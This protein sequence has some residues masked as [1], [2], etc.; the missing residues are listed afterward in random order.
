MPD[1]FLYAG[2]ANPTDIKLTDPTVVRSSGGAITGTASFV[3]SGEVIQAT[4]SLTIVGTASL[5]ESG[6]K[7]SA[8]A[9]ETFVSTSAFKEASDNLSA[10]GNELFTST[11][12][13]KESS[14]NVSAVGEQTVSSEATFTESGEEINAIG[15]ETFVSTIGL[16]ESGEKINATASEDYL[17]TA[18]LKEASDNLSATVTV[19][20]VTPVDIT[21]TASMVE[22]SEFIG[23]N[24]ELQSLNVI[25]GSFQGRLPSIYADKVV[26]YIPTSEE[27]AKKLLDDL[28]KQ[29]KEEYAILEDEEL[30]LVLALAL[31]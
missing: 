3:E 10:T 17:S 5:T 20:G 9:T 11:I 29:A 4:G 28:L 13:L 22:G 18:L 27:I 19:S 12:A 23:A 2:E 30:A 21:A 1:I 26:G 31:V 7:I 8:T 15:S 14:D 16:T 25:G 24:C 6:E